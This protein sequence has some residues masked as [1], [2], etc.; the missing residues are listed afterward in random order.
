MSL[1]VIVL[2][3]LLS[4]AGGR[5]DNAPQDNFWLGKFAMV[6]TCDGAKNPDYTLEI[7]P[8]ANQLNQRTLINLGGYGQRVSATVQGDS[9]IISPTAVNVGLMGQVQLSGT[10]TRRDGGLFIQLTV[11]GPGPQDTTTTSRCD[12]RGTP[13]KSAAVRNSPP[14]FSPEGSNEILLHNAKSTTHYY[15]R[16]VPLWLYA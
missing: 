6:Q 15:P 10:G 9:L 14:V 8:V 3:T 7:R 11:Q 16:L 2:T 13:F 5:Q 4:T 1:L 12:L